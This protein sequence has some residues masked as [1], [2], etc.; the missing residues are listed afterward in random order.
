MKRLKSRSLR[1]ILF[2]FNSLFILATSMLFLFIVY[3]S[4]ALQIKN[5]VMN[6]TLNTMSNIGVMIDHSLGSVYKQV[7]SITESRLFY[8]LQYSLYNPKTKFATYD[9]IDLSN[10]IRNFYSQNASIIDSTFLYLNDNSIMFYYGDNAIKDI[11]FDKDLLND[12][13]G[14]GVLAWQDPHD[15]PVYQPIYPREHELNIITVLG[16]KNSLKQGYFIT[17]INVDYLL[18]LLS[19]QILVKD[20][21]LFLSYGDTY[22]GSPSLPEGYQVS[23]EDFKNLAQSSVDPANG[24]IIQEKHDHYLF[25]RPLDIPGL[26][27]IALVP[28]VN[29]RMQAGSLY[30]L[31]WVFL[32]IV[33]ILGL[34]MN[35]I[36]NRT[37]TKPIL[38]LTEKM[39]N[40]GEG[41]FNTVFNIQGIK[42]I[43]TINDNVR[44]LLNRLMGL[45]A[46]VQR[47]QDEKRIAEI[48]ALQSQINP[49]F[50]YNT[51][52][53]IRQLCSLQEHGKAKRMID[54]L[55]M[56]YRIGVNKGKPLITL[57]EE[58]KHVKSYLDIQIMCLENQFDYDI[59]VEESLLET[60]ILKLTLQPLVENALHHGIVPNRMK[61]NLYVTAEIHSG[62]LEIL[63]SD[64][65]LGMSEAACHDLMRE[66]TSDGIEPNSR[67]YG[68]RNVHQRLS[69]TFGP[70]YGLS[71]SS[72]YMQ[73]TTVVV[74]VPLIKDSDEDVLG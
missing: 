24:S 52:Y 74:K 36:Y 72:T 5:S 31:L 21:H 1:T 40:A 14:N 10:A 53:S 54:S 59:D 18:Q 37:F 50:L 47:E 27:L 6:T 25:Y 8:Q 20:S 15:A 69:L 71:V 43:N 42:E 35:I 48:R 56:F 51:L 33:L 23:E 66:I 26:A 7:T 45:M 39:K 58:L 29:T 3:A 9:Y 57:G 38:L 30:L 22:L 13:Y 68:M 60:K 12:R 49:H 2:L 64:D 63:V 67:V 16:D 4:S 11:Y 44:T 62:N 28:K 70:Q 55:A 17:G 61:G 41:N 46:T 73:G 32:G 19:T 65:G 34:A